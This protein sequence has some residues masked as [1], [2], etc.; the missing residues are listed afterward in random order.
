MKV[1]NVIRWSALGV[2][3][4]YFVQLIFG[5]LFARVL[6]PEEFGAFA[7]GASF[8]IFFKVFLDTGISS[9]IIYDQEINNKDLSSIFYFLVTQGVVLWLIGYFLIA[10]LTV[11]FY[12]QAN[13]N[14]ITRTYSLVFPITAL[15]VINVALLEKAGKVKQL[16]IARN[17]GFLI[18]GGIGLYLAKEGFG[19]NSLLA[20]VLISAFVL[21][22]LVFIQNKWIPIFYFSFKSLKRVLKYG[23]P[24]VGSNLLGFSLRSLDKIVIGKANGDSNLGG[25]DKLSQYNKL[26]ADLIN[27]SVV[28]LIFPYLSRQK[29]DIKKLHS[30]YHATYQVLI[31][32]SLIFIVAVL[33][34]GEFFVRYI[35]GVQWLDYL[36]VL[37]IT[38]PLLLFTVVG[39][40]SGTIFHVLGE[41]KMELRINFLTSF[42][43]LIFIPIYLFTKEYLFLVST[44]VFVVSAIAVVKFIYSLRLIAT[45]VPEGYLQLKT[46]LLNVMGLIILLI[47]PGLVAF[48]FVSTSIF[49]N[50]FL[51]IC[52][53][54][55]IALL[56]WAFIGKTLI[57]ETWMKLRAILNEVY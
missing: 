39:K 51:F 8:L 29:E 26:P 33:L 7:M 17:A 5:I 49:F 30:V 28:S 42:L 20:R 52:Y 56:S 36:S 15:T 53:G 13:L 54:C 27:A 48:N 18:G 3:S 11:S 47:I 38:S 46:A 44:Y 14:E 45:R 12:Q 23:L 50:I 19:Y 4:A 43:Y 35:L 22:I 2:F 24:I 9:Y 16:Q 31:F 34:C 10:N 40:I 32:L 21:M 57:K 55:T 41:T 37:Y 25:Y 1:K 6:G